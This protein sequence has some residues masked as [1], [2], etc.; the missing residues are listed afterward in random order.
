MADSPHRHLALTST[1]S[2]RVLS[3]APRVLTSAYST[4]TR[5]YGGLKDED[6]IF[7]N[8]YGRH[9]WKL[10]G[11]QS[12]GHWYK[13]KV[14]NECRMPLA[15]LVKFVHEEVGRLAGFLFVATL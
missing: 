13:T 1:G 12:R 14:S 9:D 6:R 15:M 7:T 5:T 3:V 4:A 8:L 10:K 2:V 11:A